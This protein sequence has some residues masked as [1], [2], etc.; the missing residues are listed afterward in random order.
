M[1]VSICGKGGSGKSTVVTLLAMEIRDRGYRPL[2]IDADESNATLYRMLGLEKSP[3]PLVELAGGRKMVRE[4]MPYRYAPKNPE[5]ETNVL[6]RD[7]IS[8]GDIPTQYI[9]EINNIRLIIIG[10]ILQP[11]E[12]CACP[13]GVLDREF[14]GKLQLE[15]DEISIID[16]EAGIEHLGRGVETNIDSILMVVEPSL[17]SIV[18][19]EKI[20]NLASGLG[21]DGIWAV[22]NK[23]NSDELTLKLTDDLTR[24]G[25]EVAGSIPYDTEVFEACLEGRPL[26]K[27]KAASEAGKIVDFMISCGK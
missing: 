26:A 21:M 9:G 14:L 1:K 10:K 20:K 13:M 7:E 23:S 24:R 18:L 16:M 25:I 5:L 15:E 19:A 22:L 3:L 27:S 4:L 8:L 6:S 11:L 12:G 17:E 2:V